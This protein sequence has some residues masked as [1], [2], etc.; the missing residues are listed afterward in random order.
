MNTIEADA[1]GIAELYIEATNSMTDYKLL[2]SLAQDQ[3]RGELFVADTNYVWWWAIGRHYMPF[4][5][6]E[7]GTRFGYSMK[8][9]V[10]GS[11]RAPHSYRLA[12][13][14]NESNPGDINPLGVFARHFIEELKICGLRLERVNT[15]DIT[16]L[17]LG[18]APDMVVVDAD[19]SEKGCLHDCGL[20]FAALKPGGVLVVDDTRPGDNPVR[21]AAERFA[22]ERGLHYA[23][24]PSLTGITIM[25]K[26]V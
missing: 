24:L 15:Q 12:A 20:A 25:R 19:H 2:G 4:D 9:L 26:P 3:D 14:D 22:A 21:R 17:R 6:A 13:F 16:D 8:A 10:L 5:I 11:G 1:N 7:I 23:H 18:W